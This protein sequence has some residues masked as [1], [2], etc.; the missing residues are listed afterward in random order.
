MRTQPGFTKKIKE[1][2][3]YLSNLCIFVVDMKRSIKNKTVFTP[4]PVLIIATYDEKHIPDAM[5]VAWGGQCGKN[6]V[7]INLMSGH[8]TARNIKLNRAFSLSFAT[9]DTLDIADYVR[10]VS[11]NKISDKMSIAK[12]HITDGEI[13]NAPVIEEFPLTM[14]CRVVNVTDELGE[15]RVVGEVVN[16]IA[17]DSILDDD[18]NVD[19]DKLRPITYDSE[20]LTY[21]TIGGNVGKVYHDGKKLLLV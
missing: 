2:I 5:N 19:L 3:V 14:E 13:V 17:D 15:T 6:Y 8:K 18:G 9:V 10:L 12:V 4:L 7:A 21:R 16:L 11:A 20:Q 1:F